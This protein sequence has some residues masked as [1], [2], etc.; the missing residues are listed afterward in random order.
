MSEITVI[1]EEESGTIRQMPGNY[2]LAYKQSYKGYWICDPDPAAYW[3]VVKKLFRI[4]FFAHE[5]KW[6][7]GEDLV[8]RYYNV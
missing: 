7:S 4:I 3:K 2:L 8:K 1:Y 6:G 5:M